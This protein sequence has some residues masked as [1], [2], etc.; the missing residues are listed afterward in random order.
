MVGDKNKNIFVL[1]FF[2]PP[3]GAKFKVDYCY[4]W[5][6]SMLSGKVWSTKQGTIYPCILNDQ[7]AIM[8]VSVSHFVHFL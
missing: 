6:V 3:F 5:I 4:M 1:D 2:K 7:K 8:V